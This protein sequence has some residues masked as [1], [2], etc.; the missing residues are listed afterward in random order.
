MERVAPIRHSYRIGL[1]DLYILAHLILFISIVD[2]KR[3]FENAISKT[4]HSCV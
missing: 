3:V 2:S 1:L 4:A